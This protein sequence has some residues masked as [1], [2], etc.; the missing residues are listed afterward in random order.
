[1][2]AVGAPHHVTQRANNRQ[3]TFFYD[4]DCRFYLA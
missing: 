1:V 4:N 3:K 2:V